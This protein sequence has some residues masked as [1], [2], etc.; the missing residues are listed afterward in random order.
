MTG[1]EIAVSIAGFSAI[2]AIAIFFVA[3][4]APARNKRLMRCPETGAVAFVDTGTARG[5]RAARE[6][7]VQWCDLW[8]ARRYCARGCLARYPQTSPGYRVNLE[9]LRPFDRR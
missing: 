1:L 7:T 8:P 6:P 4:L 9:A 2:A 5:E 3:W